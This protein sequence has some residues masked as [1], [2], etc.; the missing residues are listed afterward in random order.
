[1]QVPA[2]RPGRVQLWCTQLLGADTAKASRH[3][4]DVS[5]LDAEPC[6]TRT[7][8]PCMLLP[9]EVPD[10]PAAAASAPLLP[11]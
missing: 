1:M 11:V 7:C 4:L 5:V 10:P 3:S 2:V 6:T 8:A 9:R